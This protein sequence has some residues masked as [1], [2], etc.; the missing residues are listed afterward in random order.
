MTAPGD[1]RLDLDDL[2]SVIEGAS[3]IGRPAD[4]V[5]DDAGRTWGERLDDAGAGVA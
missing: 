5:G 1:G 3:S 4:V 2:G